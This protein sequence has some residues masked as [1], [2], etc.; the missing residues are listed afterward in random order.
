MCDLLR[1]YREQ[2][3][4]TQVQLA[5]RMGTS[6]SQIGK[7][8]RGE[9]KLDIIELRMFCLAIGIKPADFVGEL[10]RRLSEQT[11]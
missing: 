6:Q 7:T 10:D 1:E 11:Q 3:G 5:E 8:E 9:R 2:A 4:L